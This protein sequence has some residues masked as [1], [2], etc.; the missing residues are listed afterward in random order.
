MPIDSLVN[1]HILI[2]G[3]SSGMGYAAAEYLLRGKAVV[4]IGGRDQGR[5]SAAREQLLRVS[6]CAADHLRSISVDATDLAA[7]QVAVGHATNTAGRLDGIFVVA[8]V[9]DFAHVWETSAEFLREQITGNVGPLANAIAAGFPRMKEGGG[10]IVAICANWKTSCSAVAPWPPRGRS[11]RINWKSC[12][13][14]RRAWTGSGR[15]DRF[16]GRSTS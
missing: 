14:W 11:S 13:G 15:T 5:L 9:G 8:G 12:Y 1:R 7:V 3:G 6:A 4:T 2:L 10:S 16:G